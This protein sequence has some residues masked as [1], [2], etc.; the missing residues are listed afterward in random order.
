MD[1]RVLIEVVLGLA[2][3][4]VLVCMVSSALREVVAR[5]LGER[6]KFLR[7]ALVGL[8]PDR[9]V[10]LRLINHPIVAVLYR[11]MPGQGTPPSYIPSSNFA[12]ALL[13]TLIS[14][15]ARPT[16][17]FTLDAIRA[18]VRDAKTNDLA[19]GHALQPLVEQ[20]KTV[21][22][23]LKNIED[24]YNSGM[25]RVS[26]WYKNRSQKMLFAIGF[27]VAVA[28]NIDTLAI[29]STLAQ[30]ANLRAATVA[31]AQRLTPGSV[32]TQEQAEAELAKLAAAG[33]PMGYACVGK[34]ASGAA[35][36]ETL[37]TLTLQ[38]L[39]TTCLPQVL[40]YGLGYWLIKMIGWLLTALAAALGAPFWFDLVNRLINLRS[41]SA[42][43]R[44]AA[45]K[46]SS[47]QSA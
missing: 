9:W 41:S 28:F 24:W 21:E 7:R 30:S 32:A 31:V 22:G 44:L 42:K 12:Y 11:Q 19:I 5:F 1:L 13:D 36:R 47:D 33:L 14:R 38:S 43:P 8:V 2:V 37:Q 29:G 34:S 25:E 20:A 18:A 39:V 35:P 16:G 45:A 3:V 27:M 46:G 10:Y 4:Y 17:G 26:G 23:A 15:Q 6:G 40:D